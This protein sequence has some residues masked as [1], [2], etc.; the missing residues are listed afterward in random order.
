MSTAA[1]PPR[2]QRRGRPWRGPLDVETFAET[3][4]ADC[5]D[6]ATALAQQ[7]DS[8]GV[9]TTR[10]E[11]AWDAVA[12]A[13]H[14]RVDGRRRIGFGPLSAFFATADG[15]VRTHANY[16]HHVAAL[17]SA[18]SLPDDAGPDDVAR[19]LG[20]LPSLEAE[21]R[22]TAAGGLA[23]AVRTAA[24]GLAVAVRTAAELAAAE[25]VA[26]RGTPGH[27]PDHALAPGAAHRLPPL[28]DGDLPLRGLRVMALTR[29]L[30]GP[31]AARLLASLGA[32]VL[33]IDP[34]ALPELPDQHLDTGF[35]LRT[36]EADLAT[37]EVLDRVHTLLQRA[38]VLL[39]GY[40]PGALA[41]FD[42]EGPGVR[43]RHPGLT[44]VALSAWG[45]IG[46]WAGRRGFDSLVQA[47]SGIADVYR[48]ADGRPGALPVQAL[49]YVT[50]FRVA[51]S[52]MRLLAARARDGAGSAHL[53][54]LDSATE[55]LALPGPGGT[56]DDAGPELAETDSPSGRLLHVPPPFA[57]GGERLAHRWAPRPYGD[58]ELAWAGG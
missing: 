29:V 8:A 43:A 11:W 10:P 6:A 26:V 40:R 1:A 14:L 41:R 51:T 24:G 48:G 36:A 53:A 28:A 56:P 57:V 31:S 44:V 33:R 55:L 39:T 17:R 9:V 52:A 50:G 25:P 22:V 34:P 12:T 46:P 2:P 27:R 35:G 20:A 32:D 38:D 37:R 23:V 21:E 45:T 19:A 13:N 7:R 58:D 18:L 49:D 3:A 30:A 15:W 47:A 42:L 54:L 4:A 16:P 5:A